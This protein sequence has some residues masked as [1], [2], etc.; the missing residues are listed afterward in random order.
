[1]IRFKVVFSDVNAAEVET[2][3]YE[4]IVFE[5]E[6]IGSTTRTV[7]KDVATSEEIASG[8]GGFWYY[9]GRPYQR[10]FLRAEEE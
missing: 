3:A 1:M 5:I 8:Y 10:C 4:Q 7:I 9:D 2:R 6:V